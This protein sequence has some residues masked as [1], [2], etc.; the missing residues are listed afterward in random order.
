MKKLGIASFALATLLAT[1]AFPNA[2]TNNLQ[3]ENKIRHEI[4]MLPYYGVFDDI[5][6][7]VDQG[8]VTLTGDTIRPTVRK[9][10]E[11]A[12][13]RVAGVQRVVNNIE[14]LPLSS[15]DDR[16][17]LGV[18]RA[19][20]WEPALMRY[21]LPVVPSIHIIVKNGNVRLE[22]VVMNEMD[23]NLAYMRASGVPGAF[24]VT[25]NLRVGS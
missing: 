13:G 6:F 21:S 25:N 12:V 2:N 10:V 23:R 16:V 15:H 22:G 3:L 1:S 5:S 8:V 7:Q 17:R 11:Q 18:L 9:E 19:I 24:S 20:Y 14:V 4:V